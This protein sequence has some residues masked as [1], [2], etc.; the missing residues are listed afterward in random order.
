MENVPPAGEQL[1]LIRTLTLNDDVERAGV[2]L[3]C[4]NSYVL[5]VNGREVSRSDDWQRPQG[6]A[7]HGLLKKGDNSIIAIVRNGGD[8]ENLAAFYIEGRIRLKNGE[9]LSIQ[10]DETW[11][12]TKTIPGVTEGRLG[13][14]SAERSPSRSS[15]LCRMAERDSIERFAAGAGDQREVPMVRASLIKSDF[16]MRS[17]GRPMREQIVSMRPAELT[18]LEAI[19]PR[20]RP[21]LAAA[22][23]QGAEMLAAKDWKN[24]DELIRYVY[25]FALT[26]EPTAEEYAVVAESLGPQPASAQI[27]DFLWRFT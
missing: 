16:L 15:T 23:T 10:S 20:Q 3:T 11:T 27:E 6:L 4:D 24:T 7:I 25:L 13:A 19:D 5:F 14:L 21:T 17:L 18:T 9:I 12:F 26:R 2:V 1:V 8:Q 22:L